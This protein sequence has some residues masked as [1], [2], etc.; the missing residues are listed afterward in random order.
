MGGVTMTTT[1]ITH[2]AAWVLAHGSRRLR[3]AL[4]QGMLTQSMGVYHDER[5]AHELPGYESLGRRHISDRLNPQEYELDALARERE[6]RP[7]MLISVEIHD[8]NGTH[9]TPAIAIQLPWEPK[10][11]AIKRL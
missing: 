11:K 4:E 2:P 5:I 3:L 10:R 9:W 8:D 7:A 6:D 1:Y